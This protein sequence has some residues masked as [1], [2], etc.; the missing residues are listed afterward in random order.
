[1]QQ[2]VTAKDRKKAEFC[3]SRCPICT[4][5]REKQRG[6]RFWLV[7]TVEEGMCPACKAYAK[8][9]GRKAHEPALPCLQAEAESR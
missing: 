8:V 5:A 3:L 1:M 4:K 2:T 6:F 7:K 9:Y